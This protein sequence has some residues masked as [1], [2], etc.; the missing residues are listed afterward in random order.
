MEPGAAEAVV[1]GEGTS[2]PRPVAAGAEG[3]ETLVVDKQA[4]VVQKSAFPE[5]MTRATTPEIQEAEETGASLS[6]GAVGDEA[7]TLG[8]VCTLWAATSGLDADSEGEEEAVTRHTLERGMTWARCAFDELILPATSVC[9]LVKDSFRF[10]NLFELRQLFLFCWLQTLESSS[11]RHAREV[12]QLRAKRTQLEMQLVVARVA[13]VGAVASETSARASLDAARQSM[14]DRAI[15][16]ETTAAAA[17]TERD[18]LA[19]SLALEEAEIEKLRA[20]ASFAEEVAER[21]KTATAMT[22]TTAREAS[23]AAAREKAASR[24][25]CWSW[26][27]TCG[28]PQ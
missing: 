10:C 1:G 15:S 3:V 28:Q 19:S 4:T 21:A 25:R 27:V 12:R 6:Q 14:E 16:A 18:S 8:L 20:A 2:L 5:T 11:R 22:E 17:A 23:Q 24:Q 13:A 9:S 7:R 26:R